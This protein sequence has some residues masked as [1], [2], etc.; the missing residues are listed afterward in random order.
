MILD[1][2][3]L[4]DHLEPASIVAVVKRIGSA[5]AESETDIFIHA[6]HMGRSL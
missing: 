5:R 1:P 6:F 2:V 4:R 3:A